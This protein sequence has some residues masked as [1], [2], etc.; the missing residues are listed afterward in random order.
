MFLLFASSLPDVSQETSEIQAWTSFAKQ[1][2]CT[3]RDVTTKASRIHILMLLCDC[4]RVDLLASAANC[5]SI[6]LYATETKL[7]TRRVYLGSGVCVKNAHRVP[8]TP[9]ICK[10]VVSSLVFVTSFNIAY[11]G[12]GN[13]HSKTFTGKMAS[14]ILLR[15]TEDRVIR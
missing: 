10:V 11:W 6:F 5:L 4:M 3:N 12:K 13:G 15:R 8:P 9:L 2:L 14:E 7:S 1:V